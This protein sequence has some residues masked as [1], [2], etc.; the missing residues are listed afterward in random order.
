M[1]LNIGLSFKVT[2]IRTNPVLVSYPK[3]VQNSLKQVFP[4]YRVYVRQFTL[5]KHECNQFRFVVTHNNFRP[6]NFL[7]TCNKK[8]LLVKK[9][10]FPS[11]P[12]F[13]AVTTHKH[14]LL[15]WR[16]KSNI[17]SSKSLGRACLICSGLSTTQISRLFSNAPFSAGELSAAIL[18]LAAPLWGEFQSLRFDF[19]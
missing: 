12:A 19:P 14:S 13:I 8:K 5:P 2:T 9:C 17:K 10:A 4:F 1:W 7:F 3:Q 16:L 11:G 6:R 18:D 15:K